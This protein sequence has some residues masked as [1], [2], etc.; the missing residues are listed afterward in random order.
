[1][2]IDQNIQVISNS[3]ANGGRLL[4]VDYALD[5]NIAAR[6]KSN[7]SLML[8]VEITLREI[9]SS[10]GVFILNPISVVIF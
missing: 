5:G 10:V 3:D 9:F 2:I 8:T 7:H 1:M 6:L 4:R